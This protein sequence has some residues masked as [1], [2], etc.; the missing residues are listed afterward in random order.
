MG[1]VAVGLI[2]I[3]VLVAA[4]LRRRLLTPVSIVVISLLFSVCAA[5]GMLLALHFE[6]FGSKTVVGGKE[7]D[8]A[9]IVVLVDGLIGIVLVVIARR[10]PLGVI[11]FG[12][13][14]LVAALI[15]VAAAGAT[16]KV[17][18]VGGDLFGDPGPPSI[19]TYHVWYLFLLWAAPL[20]T[21]LLQARRIR[22]KNA[23]VPLQQVVAR[24]AAVDLRG[25]ERARTGR[26]GGLSPRGRER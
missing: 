10:K 3:L 22:R 8:A 15:L 5:F 13:V 26:R 25:H 1:G 17:R 7:V 2:V 16:C 18:V 23:S 9:S 12:A 11:A 4:V 19:E 21:I 24:P 6:L 14:T 20:V